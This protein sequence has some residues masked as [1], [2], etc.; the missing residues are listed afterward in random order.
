[1]TPCFA[2]LAFPWMRSTCCCGDVAADEQ[3]DIVN[4]IR[5]V[6]TSDNVIFICLFII[7]FI[8]FIILKLN[9]STG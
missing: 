6:S 1:M 7:I 4:N 2:A 5:L 9:K 8:P 3:L